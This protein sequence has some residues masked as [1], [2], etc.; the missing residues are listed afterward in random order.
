MNDKCPKQ[1]GNLFCKNISDIHRKRGCCKI[2]VSKIECALFKTYK[3]Y[4]EFFLWK[5]TTFGVKIVYK[6]NKKEHGTADKPVTPYFK[7]PDIARID[8][9]INVSQIRSKT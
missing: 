4:L 9:Q 3:T 6:I 2:T 1:Y 5:N 8:P 7:C